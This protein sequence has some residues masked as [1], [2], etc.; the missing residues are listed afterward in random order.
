VYRALGAYGLVAMGIF[1]V[2]LLVPFAY[3]LSTGAL[4]WGPV[5]RVSERLGV[6]V[7]RASGVPGRTGIAPSPAELEPAA[8]HTPG[9]AA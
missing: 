8:E 3:L 6:G 4:D 5:R 2:V 1:L 9:E 7:R